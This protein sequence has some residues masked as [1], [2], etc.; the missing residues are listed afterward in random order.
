MF[1]FL[2]LFVLGQSI[3]P[4]LAQDVRSLRHGKN[5]EEVILDQSLRK[6]ATLRSSNLIA[7][8]R[9]EEAKLIMDD[10][11]NA[12]TPNGPQPVVLMSMGRSGSSVIW[13]IMSNLSGHISEPLELP[14]QSLGETQW[15]FKSLKSRGDLSGQWMLDYLCMQQSQRISDG[16]NDG[17]VG[18]KWKP[19]PSIFDETALQTLEVIAKS[20]DPQIK[21]VRSRRNPLDVFISNFKHNDLI[22]GIYDPKK[23]RIPAHCL[24][25]DLACIENHHRK[26][27]GMQ[28]SVP[29]M[30][31]NLKEFVSQEDKVDQ[32]LE[33]LGVPHVNVSYELLFSQDDHV[34]VAEWG[35][36]FNFIGV[37]I[38]DGKQ[39]TVDLI[40]KA[41]NTAATS[42]SDHKII[43]K[44]YE[45]VKA[46]LSGTPFENLLH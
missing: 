20:K 9:T 27:T 13:E 45:E 40:R 6:L 24:P 17:I 28:I 35:K 18:F 16:E 23:G 26:E 25:N 39:L 34:V 21:V 30:L 7:D 43:M 32:T 36:I 42:I 3:K 15:F 5:Q 44:N 1:S 22:P 14:G 37:G 33:E 19:Y 29:N 8:P 10:K 41:P 12:L 46:A 38:K 31:S 4:S 2:S 11:C